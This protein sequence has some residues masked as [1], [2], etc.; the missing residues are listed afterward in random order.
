MIVLTEEQAWGARALA[1]TFSNDATGDER[2]VWPW[3]GMES[4][5]FKASLDKSR[6][7][8]SNDGEHVL[9]QAGIVA[10]KR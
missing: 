5:N 10:K 4:V 6:T 7:V 3:Y 2:D 9:L 1:M 8:R